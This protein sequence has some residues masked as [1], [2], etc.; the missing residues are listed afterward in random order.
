MAYLNGLVG[1]H[2]AFGC[3]LYCP[4]KGRR[5][6]GGTHYY[7]ALLKPS[8]YTVEGCT[9]DTI[10]PSQIPLSPSPIAYQ[11][12]LQIVMSSPTNAA[13]GF[14]RKNTG[15]S[16]PSIFSGLSPTHILG[17]PGCFGHDLMHLISLNLTDLFHSLWRGKMTCERTDDISTWD[18]A[19]FLDQDCWEAHGQ[20]VANCCPYLPGSFDRP[21]RNPAEK[22]SSGYKAWEFLMWMFGLGPAL[23]FHV[24]D[25]KYW[26]NFCKLT[27]AVRLLH[28]RSISLNDLH[29][30][31]TLIM[32][33]VQ[34][35]E[36]IYYQGRV[37][38]L[39]FVRPCIHTFLHLPGEV[40]RLGP[41]TI[42]TQWTMEQTIGNLGEEVKQPS[43]P[44]ANI[45][46]R[47]VLRCQINALLAM[48]PSIS[49]IP[50]P[51]SGSISLDSGYILL[52]AKDKS[53]H[54]LSPHL[55][56]V[57]QDNLSS[58]G[59]ALP[60]SQT[61]KLIRWARLKLPN[62]QIARSLWK[63]KEKHPDRL[64][65]ARNIKACILIPLGCFD[66]NYS[67]TRSSTEPLKNYVKCSFF[68]ITR[69]EYLQWFLHSPI[70]IMNFG[71]VHTRP[72]MSANTKGIKPLR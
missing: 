30:S 71:E 68:S 29:E 31:H 34:E 33:F 3:R 56:Q 40:H 72:S 21:P 12:N 44:Y 45:S 69:G 7:P 57:I 51:P 43:Q 24:L 35:F 18:W 5:K 6:D 20:R 50:P 64:R 70:L 14:N 61:I 27:R 38:R 62:G 23:F 60:T 54:V 42:Y 13:Y 53:P 65:I 17:I 1:H 59:T 63:E 4:V 19:A 58:T 55:S 67:T 46:Q 52:G 36:Q 49:P 41:S 47:G 10:S 48:F 28:R 26:K 16:K 2:G 9:H 22:V 25:T 39:H 32:D 66:Y 11:Q 8:N 15:I 37:D